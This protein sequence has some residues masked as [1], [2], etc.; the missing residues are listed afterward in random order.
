[1]NYLKI[2]RIGDCYQ[3]DNTFLIDFVNPRDIDMWSTQLLMANLVFIVLNIE[4]QF[5]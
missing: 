1:M 2:I 4:I 5:Y 3:I